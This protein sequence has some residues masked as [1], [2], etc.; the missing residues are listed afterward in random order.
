M[1]HQPV[2][3]SSIAAV[4]YDAFTATLEIR[5]H[6][7]RHYRFFLVPPHCYRDLLAADSKGRFFLR[8]I[9]PAGFPYERLDTSPSMKA[10]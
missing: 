3:S 6:S 10:G 8:N 9:R 1:T 4:G 5:F 7:G 2:R